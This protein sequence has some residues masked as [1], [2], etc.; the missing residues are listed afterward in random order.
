GGSLAADGINI[1][2]R[3]TCDKVDVVESV[4]KLAAH[5][6]VYAF[7]DPELLH[8]ADVATE[9]TRSLENQVLESAL[10]RIGLH[11]VPVVCRGNELASRLTL[12]VSAEGQIKRLVGVLA[13]LE[14]QEVDVTARITGSV[15]V[16]LID[17]DH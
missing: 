7:G 6:E 16:V 17:A 4:Q 1:V 10:T 5:F 11:A 8:N 12:G 9:E 15:A 14:R 2:A 13:H 3:T